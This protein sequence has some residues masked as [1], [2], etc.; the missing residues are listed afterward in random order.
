MYLQKITRNLAVKHNLRWESTCMPIKIAITGKCDSDTLVPLKHPSFGASGERPIWE[1][2]DKWN[3]ENVCVRARCL[4]E[5]EL[6]GVL[7]WPQRARTSQSP[8]AKQQ[9]TQQ[10][11]AGPQAA[12][13]LPWKLSKSLPNLLLCGRPINRIFRNWQRDT[14]IRYNFTDMIIVECGK[15]NVYENRHVCEVRYVLPWADSKGLPIVAPW[16]PKNRD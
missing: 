6:G 1:P 11:T 8:S 9:Q 5:Q 12:A 16:Q 7:S 15:A 14:R 4:S 10:L 3:K 13:A 2:R